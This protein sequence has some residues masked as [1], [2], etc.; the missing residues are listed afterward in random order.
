MH[1]FP[2][3]EFPPRTVRNVMAGNSVRAGTHVLAA[4][5]LPYIRLY[6]P[7]CFAR[8]LLH[9]RGSGI[10]AKDLPEPPSHQGQPSPWVGVIARENIVVSNR[11]KGKVY[12]PPGESPHPLAPDPFCLTQK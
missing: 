7:K 2:V 10:E 3:S 1:F 9:L 12:P 8:G 11:A 6:G 5:P 4:L